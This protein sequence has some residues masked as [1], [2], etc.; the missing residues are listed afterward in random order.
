MDVAIIGAGTI[1]TRLSKSFLACEDTQVKIVVD[2]D[3]QKARNLAEGLGASYSTDYRSAIENV[4]IVYVGVPPRF[5]ADIA[6]DALKQGKHVICEKPIAATTQDGMRMVEMAERSGR[7]TAINLPFRFSPALKRMKQS[8]SS[9]ELGR[10]RH[11]ELRFRFPQWPRPWQNVEWLKHREQGGPL[12]EVGTHYFFALFELFGNVKKVLAM[13][14]FG[15]DNLCETDSVGL[16][17]TDQG[18]VTLT[19]ITGGAEEEENTLNLYFDQGVLTFEKWYLL[20]LQPKNE[21]LVEDRVNAELEMV[22]TF[23]KAVKGD[24]QAKHS[25]VSFNDALNAQKVL[26][27]IYS[28]NGN[29]IDL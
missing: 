9:N 5:H 29:W 13:T 26:D 12:R 7:I 6:I 22:K 2:I 17:A 24:E 8:L 27:A 4:D 11:A 21:I 18:P 16:I 10:F 20:S 25:L 19:L 23:V 3:K 28:S 14:R 15:E 1:G